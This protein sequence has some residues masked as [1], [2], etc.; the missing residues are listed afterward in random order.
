MRSFV[1][2]TALSFVG[3]TAEAEWRDPRLIASQVAFGV[4]ASFF[5][6]VFLKHRPLR[7][8]LKESLLP[9][10]AAG[11]VAHAGYSV[12][13]REPKLALV[14][15]TLAQKSTLVTR[16]AIDG[17]PF[18]DG[19]LYS[20]WALTHSMFYLR[21][22]RGKPRVELDVLNAVVSAYYLSSPQYTFDARRSLYAGSLVFKNASPDRY[23]HG[24]ATPGA[25]WLS[26]ES[27]DDPQVF[28]HELVH[29]LQIERGA[30]FYDWHAKGLRFNL[31][32][33]TSGVP[34]FLR[35]WPEHDH[36]W[37][38]READLY[39]GRK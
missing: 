2:V 6:K 34:A 24:F 11:L 27:Y 26:P 37:H 4:G 16:R 13:G 30:G 18:F 12:A 5:G 31:L 17:E 38:E 19:S 23:T 3:R 25:I 8:A 35:G 7:A 32:A 1:L 29:T 28:G 22:E 33:F 39:A 14:G 36:R 20:D 15:K 21:L 9:G 10:V